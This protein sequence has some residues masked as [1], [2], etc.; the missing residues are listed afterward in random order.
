LNSIK[1]A[2]IKFNTILLAKQA[3]ADIFDILPRL[4][5]YTQ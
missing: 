2:L 4:Q 1:Q 3:S 5:A